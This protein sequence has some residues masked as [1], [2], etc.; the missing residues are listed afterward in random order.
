[1]LLDGLLVKNSVS[2]VRDLRVEVVHL[3]DG[4]D[5]HRIVDWIVK[6]QLHDSVKAILINDPDTVFTLED[7]PGRKY[8]NVLSMLGLV[9]I[10]AVQ[11]SRDK[12]F[13]LVGLG[14]PNQEL[15]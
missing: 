7:H 10:E 11:A 12:D 5:G 15:P 3:A 2:F 13:N 9:H 6:V 8:S 4:L 1:M 14:R